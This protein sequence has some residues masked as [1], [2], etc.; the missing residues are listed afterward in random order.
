M[1]DPTEVFLP[2]GLVS[3]SDCVLFAGVDDVPDGVGAVVRDE[4]G[5]ILGFCNTD[6][7][8][9]DVPV[10]DGEAGEEV[11]VL[12]SGMAVLHGQ[13]NDFIAGALGAVPGAVFACE[14]ISFVLG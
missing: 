12:A 3:N 11:F 1:T 5:A 7:A 6:G 9:P 8:T 2:W 4:E 10:A 14:A 13:A